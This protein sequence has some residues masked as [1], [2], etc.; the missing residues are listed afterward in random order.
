MSTNTQK[1]NGLKVKT[2]VKAGSGG[3]GGISL[4][5]N[6]TLKSVAKGLKVRS[7]INAG[8]YKLNHNETVAVDKHNVNADLEAANPDD[9]KGGPRLSITKSGSFE[10]EGLADLEP[11]GDVIGGAKIGAGHL[12]L[13]DANTYTGTTTV[14]EGTLSM[15]YQ[16]KSGEF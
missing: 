5:H 16:R 8:G 7:S 11:T 15:N 4:N 2:N 1:K 14:N 6:K 3:F 10:E 13:P 12:I 9:I